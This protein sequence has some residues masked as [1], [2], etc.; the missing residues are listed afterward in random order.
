MINHLR[1]VM[2]QKVKTCS[3]RQDPHCVNRPAFQPV[4]QEIRLFQ[5]QGIAPCTAF[6]NRFDG[7]SLPQDQQPGSRSAV[8]YLVAR[9]AETVDPKL[10]DVDGENARRLSG[11]YDKKDPLFPAQRPQFPDG[12]DRPGNI[13]RIRTGDGLGVGA[14]QAAKI[15]HRLFR[16]LLSYCRHRIRDVRLPAQ[17]VDR[18]DHR[19]MFQR[20]GDN[21]PGT[22]HDSLDGHI[23]RHGAVQ[24]KYNVFR[25]CAEKSGGLLP[26]AENL[27]RNPHGDLVPASPGIPPINPHCVGNGQLYVL[28]FG[29]AGRRIVKINHRP[30]NLSKPRISQGP[31]AAFRFFMCKYREGFPGGALRLRTSN[32]F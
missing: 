11:V 17:S 7:N 24:G 12:Q 1:P 29:E 10:P 19:I 5:F 15:P 22:S 6:Q 20:R 28:G 3:Q 27:F 32:D 14:D 25:L 16:I 30:P 9:H 13:G 2:G 23:Q 21:M 31:G 4:R 8:K 18:P 26:D